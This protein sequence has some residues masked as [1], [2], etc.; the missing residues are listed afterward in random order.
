MSDSPIQSDD[1]DDGVDEGWLATFCDISMLLLCFFI[2]LLS[3]S[4]LDKQ[5]FSESFSSVRD[6]FGGQAR[7]NIAPTDAQSR[8][9]DIQDLANQQMQ[10]KAEQR[11]VYNDIQ[12]FLVQNS[13]D[14]QV[15]ATLDEGTITLLVPAEALFAPG[16]E[17]LTPQGRAT[18]Q[19]LRDLF[20]KTREQEISVRGYTDNSALP[21]GARYHD[22][23]ELSALRAVHVL[24]E[25]INGGIEPVRLTATGFGELNPL[26]PNDTP[27]NRAKN[28]RVEFVLQRRVIK[29]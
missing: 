26:A 19:N 16:A 2:L 29:K 17:T 20:L 14:G 7:K 13:A 6:S 11:K 27:E 15:K 10:I 18:I 12:N 3:M 5:K 1:D 24:R 9:E 21:A 22:N 23:W 25:L 4:S 8:S 28:R